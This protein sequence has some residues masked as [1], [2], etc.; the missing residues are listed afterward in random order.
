M[1]TVLEQLR[2]TLGSAYTIDRE[3][4]GGGMSRVFLADELALGRKVVVKVVAPEL[5]E[6]LSAERFTREVKLAARL[7]QANIVPLISAGNANGLP[8]YTMPFVDGLTLR[9]RLTNGTAITVAEATHVL[10]DVAKALAYAHAQGVVHRDIKPE[11]VLLSGGTAMVTDFGIAKALTASRTREL[12]DLPPIAT[13]STLTSVGSSIGTP[14]YMSPEQAVG[15]QVDL[16]S[17]LYAWG[18][19]A[20]E[21][22]AGAHPFAGRTTPQQLIAAHI[23]T[24]PPPITDRVPG[25]PVPLG[26]VIMRC[27]AKDPSERPASATEVLA[28]LDSASTPN[29]AFAGS[30]ASRVAGARAAVP[31]RAAQAFGLVLAV[32]AVAT[33]AWLIVQVRRHPLPAASSTASV[34]D[35]VNRSVAVLPLSNL[36]GDKADDYFGVGLAEEMTRTIAKA[37]VRVIGRVSAS[38]LLA[39]G[40]DERSIARELGVGSLLT[41]TVQRAADQ[42]RINV[43]L[44]AA[45]DGA[46]R[47]SERYDRPLTNVFAVQDEIARAVAGQ[48]IGSL[49]RPAAASRVET[50]DPQAYALFLQGQ[51][52]FGR[53]TAQTLQQ[54]ISLFRQA[55][56][57]DPKYARAQASLAMALGALPSY[58]QGDNNAAMATA[59]DA[60]RRAIAIDSTI[61]ESYTALAYAS[62]L[63]SDNRGADAHFRKAV[64]LD[65]SVAT[66]WGWYGL[67]A[68]RNKDFA[69]AHR[70]IARARALE[71]ASLIARVWDA[72]VYVSERRHR[73]A[74]SIATETLALD[75]TFA[76]AW[77][78]KAEALLQLGRAAEAVAILER[79]VSELPPH[80]PTETHGLLTYA[81]A[82]AGMVEKAR[83][84]L[85]AQTDDAGG[86]LPAT[87]VLATA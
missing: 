12:G 7:Q 60:A 5:V 19:M 76:L 43:S 86:R 22:L 75:S 17:D 83:A 71:P 10:R 66:A 58:V 47:W 57:R 64:A 18:V 81:Y 65:S 80:R 23:A 45:S 6:G 67:L 24:A 3:L 36:S 8:Y 77:T 50:S 38:A 25:I 20:Y 54:S 30:S 74:D 63:V 52:L 69:E 62:L 33:G 15:S 82:R 37:G 51:V 31:G 9:A 49:G 70:R 42:V 78:A 87:G 84:Q 39:K 29:A 53:R 41:G 4:G 34:P 44:V 13:S 85:A 21:L 55:V 68:S 2:S 72:Q 59:M 61:A 1:S 79:R 48:L 40:L 56:A 28:A 16:R 73:E 27:L 35:S 14:A 32:I 46:V 26:D 11:N